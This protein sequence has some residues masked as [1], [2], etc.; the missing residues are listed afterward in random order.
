MGRPESASG[1]LRLKAGVLCSP[2]PCF[3]KSTLIS[4]WKGL[5]SWVSREWLVPNNLY[6]RAYLTRHRHFCLSPRKLRFPPA[7]LPSGLASSSFL[8]PDSFPISV[9][10]SQSRVL[11]CFIGSCPA[12]SMEAEYAGVPFAAAQQLYPSVSLAGTF[13]HLQGW[14][15]LTG[16]K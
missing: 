3:F 15:R 9:V 7:H 16:L 6:F 1:V 8:P 13:E 4:S 12:A 5:G 14:Y 11:G 10:Y 2:M